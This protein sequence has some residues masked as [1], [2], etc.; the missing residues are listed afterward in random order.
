MKVIE[1][2]TQKL[3]GFLARLEDIPSTSQRYMFEPF[4]HKYNFIVYK[5]KE[6]NFGVAS[7]KEHVLREVITK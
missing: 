7:P 3:I 5:D 4:V 2:T 6:G 1:K